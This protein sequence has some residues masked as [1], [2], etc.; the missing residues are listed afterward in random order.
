MEEHADD[1]IDHLRVAAQVPVKIDLILPSLEAVEEQLEGAG[2][3]LESGPVPEPLGAVLAA[4]V[5]I[6]VVVFATQAPAT[7]VRQ[8]Q[9]GV[10]RRAPTVELLEDIVEARQAVLEVVDVFIQRVARRGVGDDPR[11]APGLRVGWSIAAESGVFLA[12]LEDLDGGVLGAVD[13]CR[14]QDAS[15]LAD[16]G[17]GLDGIGAGVARPE[18]RANRGGVARGLQGLRERLAEAVGEAAVAGGDAAGL[19]CLDEPVPQGAAPRD[20]AIEVGLGG[21]GGGGALDLAGELAGGV[22]GG[23]DEADVVSEA[24]VDAEGD[25]VGRPVA[26][27]VPVAGGVPASRRLVGDLQSEAFEVLLA[28]LPHATAAAPALRWAVAA[29]ERAVPAHA[30]P[31]PVRCSGRVR[32][33]LT[34]LSRR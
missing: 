4:E 31:C 23:T 20:V 26:P 24:R 8:G 30:V 7:V 18:R 12:P 13:P 32:A 19:E 11:P 16:G 21:E 29:P 15:G 17:D 1:Q 22:G 14:R 6:D 3:D 28:E 25:L 2:G 9:Y 5:G 33:S 10:A 34:A 27:V